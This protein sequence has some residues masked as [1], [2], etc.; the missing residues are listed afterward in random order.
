MKLTTSVAC[1][2][3]LVSVTAGAQDLYVADMLGDSLDRFDGVTGAPK[4][5]KDLLG[6]TLVPR[7]FTP[8]GKTSRTW[9]LQEPIGVAFGPDG[10]VYVSNGGTSSGYVYEFNPKTGAFLRYLPIYETPTFGPNGNMFVT[11]QSGIVEYD[12]NTGGQV[13]HHG[14]PLGYKSWYTDSNLVGRLVFG[15]DGNM[16]VQTSGNAII[17]FS[18]KTGAYIG[19]FIPASPMFVSIQDYKFG[20]DGNFYISDD[21]QGAIFRFNG[22]TGAPMPSQGNTGA[23]FLLRSYAT[24]VMIKPRQFTFGPDGSIYIVDGYNDVIDRFSLT[25]TPE[26]SAGNP[27]ATFVTGEGFVGQLTFEQPTPEPSAICIAA[28]LGLCCFALK[29]SRKMQY[30]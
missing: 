25:G 11:M 17:K 7:G 26:P 24:S 1:F 27:Y 19:T 21:Q 10:G 30:Q 13:S 9:G 16:Y 2:I 8:P 3:A 18:G 28:S 6:A 20:P 29:R 12:T 5:G 23:I 4:P 15:P 22:Q 14:N